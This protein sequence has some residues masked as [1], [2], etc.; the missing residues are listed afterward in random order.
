[1]ARVR[2]PVVPFWPL[3]GLCF[4]VLKLCHVIDWHWALVTAPWWGWCLVAAGYATY[5][6]VRRSLR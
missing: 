3:L 6:D 1:M 5:L 4:I 2:G